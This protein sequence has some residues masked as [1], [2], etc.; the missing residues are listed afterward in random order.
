VTDWWRSFSRYEKA[1]LFLFLLTLPFVHPAVE[2]DGVGYYAYLR[3][4]LIDH[5]FRFASDYKDPKSELLSIYLDKHFVPNP[6][7]KT[8]HLPNF[9]SVGP[10]ILWLPFIAATHAV[11]LALNHFGGS[12]AADGHSRPY[13]VVLSVATALYG[14]LGL[15][16]SFRLARKYVEER[17]AFWAT[18][19]IWLASSLPLYIYLYPS[20]SHAHSVF[21][22]SLFLWYWDKT[23]GPR[24][25]RLWFVLGLLSGL[26]V[27][28]Y[29]ANFVFLLA[30]GIE[31]VSAYLRAWRKRVA[32]LPEFWSNVRLHLWYAAGGFLALLPTFIARE[33]VYGSPFEAGVYA[34]V[35]WRWAHPMFRAVLFDTS[36]GLFVCTPILLLAVVGLFLLAWHKPEIGRPCLAI[37]I[38]FYV[39]I[40]L[41]PWW[42]GA[43]GFGNRLFVSL[44]PIFVLS[45]SFLFSQA[46]RIWSSSR[47]AVWRLVPVTMLF[48]L[49]NLGLVYQWSVDMFPWRSQVYWDE[50]LYDQFH[51]VPQQAFRDLRA[52]FLGHIEQRDTSTH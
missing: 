4:P 18:L 44:T 24:T 7:T 3:S 30:P 47:A 19:A 48:I 38:A 5:N 25:P 1:L 45:L 17:W 21:C 33:I 23:R 10:A 36:H 16:I 34:D 9:Y 6:I 50:V 29:S 12:L 20:W 31:A 46:A 42:Y 51:V 49:W 35:R 26:L 22:A 40:S 28:V 13:I 39:L 14:F 27:D 43:F 41:Y 37:S 8:G 32:G 2:G 11:V 52:K 15:W